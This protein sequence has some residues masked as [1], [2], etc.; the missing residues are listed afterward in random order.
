MTK[1]GVA[2]LILGAAVLA[3]GGAWWFTKNGGEVAPQYR[4][5]SVER[6]QIVATIS[7]SGTINPVG[8]V[9]VGSQISGQL[10]EVLVD[11]NSEVRAG[12]V[13]ARIDPET[14]RHRLAQAEA[15]LLA[16]RAQV[17][18]QQAQIEAR[19]AELA[20][21]EVNLDESRRDLDR[22]RD[23][24]Q[25]GFIS[26]AEVDRAAALV[27][28]QQQELAAGRA[29][30]E[31]AIAQRRNT[32]A[33]VRQREAAVAAA[34]VDLDRT[35]IRSPVD[36]VVIKRSVDAGQTVAA[37]LQ[38]PELFVIARNLRDMQVD[39]S[40][41]ETDI[42]RIEVGQKAS[43]TVDAHPGRRFEG[44]VSQLR[45]AATNVQNVIT[46]NVIVTFSNAEGLLLPGMTANVRVVA[47][48]R[49]EVLKV[50][51]AALRLRIPGLTDRDTAEAGQGARSGATGQGGA[52]GRSARLW[53]LENGEPRSIEVRTGLG[54][55]SSTEV[56]SP[57]LAEG[58]QVIVGLQPA[59]GRGRPALR[60]F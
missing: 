32:E 6:G 26:T 52:R 16:T 25:R 7:A 48:R 27:R 23:L 12:Q 18:V 35:V 5:A 53:L 40:I 10:R 29:A 30:I 55:G 59:T 17:A 51:N 3:A 28:A 60:M 46:Y 1:T 13:L 14:F 9:S 37:S 44:T 15:D 36:G 49:D 33:V 45:M 11:F 19:R 54:D 22:K 20:R 2:G 21:V 43:F 57:E 24:A 38:A 42:G 31:V 4:T 39:T 8:S 58:A 41:D 56:H 50:P 47:E 34:R